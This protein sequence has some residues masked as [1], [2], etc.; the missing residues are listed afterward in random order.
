MYYS[1]LLYCTLVQFQM[2]MLAPKCWSSLRLIK[3]V[4]STMVTFPYGELL[5]TVTHLQGINIECRIKKSS[6]YTRLLLYRGDVPQEFSSGKNIWEMTQNWIETS[7]FFLFFSE[8]EEARH[9][10]S[11]WGFW[12]HQHLVRL[13]G[14]VKELSAWNSNVLLIQIWNILPEE[15]RFFPCDSHPLILSDDL[16]I[17][18]NATFYYF[19]CTNYILSALFLKQCHREWQREPSREQHTCFLLPLYHDENRIQRAWEHDAFWKPFNW[20]SAF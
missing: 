11:S 4:S 16:W 8:L 6:V 1:V 2:K 18:S 12:V 3:L 20:S 14:R 5:P 10:S 17:Y 13:V 15:K 9:E 7:F 19:F